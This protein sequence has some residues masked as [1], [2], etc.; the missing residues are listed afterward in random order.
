MT[1]KN[2]TF[3]SPT[4][5][6]FPVSATADRRLYLM[7]GGMNY[8]DY[9]MKHWVTPVNSGFNRIYKDSSFII[10]GAYF[11]LKEQAVVVSANTNS[12]IH[13]N[14][15][16]SNVTSPVFVTVETQD[17]SNSIDINSTSGILKKC[18]ENVRTNASSI[19]DVTETS[20]DSD[21]I[22]QLKLAMN[23]I[24]TVITTTNSANPSNYLGGTWERYGQGRALVGIDENDDDF[25]AIGKTGGEKKHTL[26]IEEMPSHAHQVGR[27][28]PSG[29]GFDQSQRKLAAAPNNGTGV[30]GASETATSGGDKAHNNMQ[31]YISV[32]M[33][34]RT[35]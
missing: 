11:E 20:Q 8:A 4:G 10:G 1:I 35:A 12:Y 34:R 29:T 16:L 25:S 15:D 3:F 32:Y 7:L 17:N 24:G 23:P 14:I 26:T 19:S 13:V 30:A 28:N 2:Y 9:K 33:F 6:E 21:L 22:K 18:V 5:T 31:P 27:W